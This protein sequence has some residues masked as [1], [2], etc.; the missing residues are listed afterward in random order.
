M[1]IVDIKKVA[2]AMDEADAKH[3]RAQS[4]ELGNLRLWLK[5]KVK[6]CQH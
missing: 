6:K 2:K 5:R 3:R 1:K 4:V